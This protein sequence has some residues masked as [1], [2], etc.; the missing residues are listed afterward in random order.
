MSSTR[1]TILIIDD[2][3]QIREATSDY[4]EDFG[5]ATLLA[6][7]GRKG[8]DLFHQTKPDAVIVDL[9]M[10]D[11]DGFQVV[12][13][14]I[15]ESPQTPIIVF[16]GIG[17]IEKAVQAVREGAWDFLAKP[18]SSFE[19]LRITIERCLER[20]RL[21]SENIRYKEHL[22][23]EIE[24]K[25]RE[26]VELG[27]EVINTQKEIIMTLG[28]VVE[29]RSKETAYHV[30]R[31]AD[32][33]YLLAREYGL[34]DETASQIRIAAPMHD[35][36]KIGIPD[37]ILNTKRNLTPEEFEIIKTHTQIGFE[38]FNKSSLPVMHLAAVIAHEHHEQWNGKGYP[39]NLKGE[40]ISIGG[41]I[42]CIVDVFDALIHDRI[43]KEAWSLGS[44]IEYMKENEG[45]LFDPNLLKIFIR[46]I[47]EFIAIN[48]SYK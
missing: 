2:E 24:R 15:S 45:I 7:D 26:I 35:V 42:T 44:A 1:L 25:T 18:L 39:R 37:T 47:D 48:E 33:A 20:A 21:I 41:R 40:E 38:I 34:S 5:F 6:E 14:V 17:I 4:L 16:S 22:E 13:T 43:Y 31:V 46:H 19:V 3:E 12:H 9:S 32:Y 23:D 29:T 36:G 28:D 11:I 8:I 30:R 10:P 27:K